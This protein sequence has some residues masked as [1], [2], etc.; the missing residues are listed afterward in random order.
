MD[1]RKGDSVIVKRA[2]DVIPQITKIDNKDGI[3]RASNTKPPTECPSCG[4]RLVRD[5]GA[6]AL[7]CLEAQSCPAQLLEMIKHFVSRNAMNIEGLGEKIIQLLI[8]KELIKKHPKD[9]SFFG[10]GVS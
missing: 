7:R 1:V 2:G 9:R 3:K 6:A 8:T 4:S 5:E 10:F